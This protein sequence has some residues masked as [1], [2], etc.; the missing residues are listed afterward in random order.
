[1]IQLNGL[2]TRYAPVKAV[3]II[4]TSSLYLNVNKPHG[5]LQTNTN[6]ITIHFSY[7]LNIFENNE[8]NKSPKIIPKT[9]LIIFYMHPQR[10]R[11]HL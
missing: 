4:I 1:M 6:K 2:T 3:E 5:M 7:K 10:K 8:L 11:K 9:K